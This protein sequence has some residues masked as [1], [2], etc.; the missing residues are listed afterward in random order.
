MIRTKTQAGGALGSECHP[1]A[2]DDQVHP[3]GFEPLTFGSV[4]RCSIQLS[5]GCAGFCCRVV[6]DFASISDATP[7]QGAKSEAGRF[8]R[9]LLILALAYLLLVGLGLRARRRYRAG[10]WCSSNDPDQCSVF[11]IGRTML[12]RMRQRCD[13]VFDAVAEATVRSAPNWG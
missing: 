9:L 8:D 4:D 6:L 7:T 5:Y 11:T 12:D 3:R 2:L 1:M 13:T 10:M